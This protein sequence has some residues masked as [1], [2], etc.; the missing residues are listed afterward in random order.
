MVAIMIS[1][2]AIIPM[3]SMFDMALNVA[4][5]GSN[6]DRGRALAVEQL[7]EI[8][9]LPFSGTSGSLVDTYPPGSPRACVG[10]VVAG[11]ACQVETTYVRLGPP[12]DPR[13]VADPAARTM[14]EVEVTVTW[15]GGSGSYTTTGLITKE[16]RCASGC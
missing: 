16:T 4:T 13:V 7:E 8:R 15:S 3:I 5:R 11:F 10:S 6:Y 2:I 1:A 14:I 12:G 9:A